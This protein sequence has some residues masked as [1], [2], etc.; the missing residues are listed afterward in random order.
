MNVAVSSEI[1]DRKTNEDVV[2]YQII[3]SRS[4]FVLCDG[5]G[6]LPDGGLAAKIVTDTLL[7][8]F[9]KQDFTLK[10]AIDHA[11][12]ILLNRQSWDHKQDGLRTTLVVLLIDGKTAQYAYLGDSR[13]YH[14]E[15]DQLIHV[16]SDDVVK[17]GFLHASLSHA[18]GDE[19]IKA[20]HFSKCFEVTDDSSFLL[21]SDGFYKPLSLRCIK[22]AMRHAKSET[23]L[24][25]MNE[26]IRKHTRKKNADN[27]SA[28][29]IRMN[30]LYKESE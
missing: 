9:E 11:Q 8:A 28:I 26:Q 19:S 4:F 3:D 7:E 10:Q 14:F 17:H 6:G 16:T 20:L 18:M 23:W 29:A 22:K 15:G 12:E 30:D 27:Y 21:C 5:V 25:T 1:G 13:L 24:H 2:D